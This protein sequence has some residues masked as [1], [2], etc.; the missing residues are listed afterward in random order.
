TVNTP[1]VFTDPAGVCG[2]NT[3]CFTSIQGAVN[4]IGSAGT[5]NVGGGTYLE[6]I[7]INQ[8]I[9]V[10]VNGDITILM[11]IFS[12][13]TINAGSS[14]VSVGVNFTNNGGT[15]NTVTG[16]VTLNGT[17]PQTIGG[18]VSTIFNN[19]TINNPSQSVA[20]GI[21]ETVNG[22]LTLTHD[23]DTGSFT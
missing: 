17:G 19:L 1:T 23:L 13:C 20:L 5:V 2:G 15:F 16:T 6:V 12:Q 8:P 21:D 10:N 11:L 14:N 4:S 9:I 3:P 22:V 18:S 7:N